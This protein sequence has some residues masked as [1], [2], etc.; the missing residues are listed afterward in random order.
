LILRDHALS[1]VEVGQP[2]ELR[3]LRY[4]V[5][6]AEELHFRRAAERLH[7]AQPPLSQQILAFEQE[8]NVKLF[9]RTK[10]KVELSHAG[11]L[12]LDQARQILSLAERAAQTAQRA[13]RGE[14]GHLAIGLSPTADLIVLPRILPEF[15]KRFPAIDLT[16]YGLSAK[17]QIAAIHENRLQVGLVRLPG[18]DKQLTAEPLMREPLIAVLPEGHRLASY[19]RIPISVI[20]AEPH[21]LFPRRNA[22]SY[23]DIIVTLYREAGSSLKVTQEVDTI[24]TTLSLVAAGLGVSIQPQSVRQLG[25]TGVVYRPLRGR[26]PYVEIGAIYRPGDRSEAL[27]SFL[28]VARSIVWKGAGS[29]PT[30]SK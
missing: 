20:A 21:V 2:M 3:H 14:I 4:F 23:Y 16:L 22:P 6:V 1:T 12:L 11:Q 24:Q 10:R 18:D 28:T 5:A 8:L 25:R 7:I 26:V 29:R 17:D 27:Q 19:Q 30:S 15:R 13:A 9:F